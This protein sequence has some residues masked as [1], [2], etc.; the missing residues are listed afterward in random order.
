[1]KEKYNS[2]EEKIYL[3]CLYEWAISKKLP[4]RDSKWM[5]K[6]ELQNWGVFLVY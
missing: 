6:K 2:E 5:N 3:P 4:V 1:M